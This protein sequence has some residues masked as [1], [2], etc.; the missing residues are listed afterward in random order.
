MRYS[1]KLR[2][3][4][5]AGRIS[6]GGTP[7]AIHKAAEAKKAAPARAGEESTRAMREGLDEETLT[8]FDLL[9]KPDLA[10]KDIDRIKKVAVDLLALFKKK[11]QEIDDWRAKEQ[12]RDEV[13][14][15]IH[16]LLYSD[17]AGLPDTFGEDEITTN[18]KRFLL[19][20]TGLTHDVWRSV[21]LSHSLS[22]LLAICLLDVAKPVAKTS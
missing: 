1:Y 21:I 22:S 20:F 16:D 8:L 6:R 18:R 10:K 11:K 3:A 15:A 17:A 19:M 7:H 4:S 14:Q 12:T 13:R 2:L 5:I 9:K